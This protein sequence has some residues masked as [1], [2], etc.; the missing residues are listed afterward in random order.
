MI[1]PGAR[2]NGD[3]ISRVDRRWWT[4]RA[5]YRIWLACLRQSIP[6]T[7]THFRGN[8]IDFQATCARGVVFHEAPAERHGRGRNSRPCRTPGRR[9]GNAID[10]EAVILSH[11]AR[12]KR[13][14]NQ[15]P[16]ENNRLA[17]RERSPQLRKT[18]EPN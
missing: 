17:R 14:H 1:D 11:C 6:A 4:I 15:Q 18:A 12:L 2:I 10:R 5:A 13:P 7:M 3:L 16:D 8:K 9:Q